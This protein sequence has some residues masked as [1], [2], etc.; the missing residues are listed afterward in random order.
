MKAMNEHHHK[1][2]EAGEYRKLLA[3]VILIVLLASGF[4]VLQ[5]T[6]LF[7]F[8]SNFMGVFL[9]TFAMF[10]IIRLS[11]FVAIYKGYDTI[12]RYLPAWAFVYPFV[13]LFIS[14]CYLL[15]GGMQ[16]LNVTTIILL[17]PASYGVW[18]EVTKKSKIQC[19]C[20][21]SVV[22]LPLSKV[23]FIENFTMLAMAVFMLLF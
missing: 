13:E 1:T 21:G 18:R 7:N 16:W 23:S 14:A 9:M 12:S 19:A 6:T 15:L 4:T 17:V 5:E 2:N 22:K 11:E 20:L 8:L 3:I 10:K